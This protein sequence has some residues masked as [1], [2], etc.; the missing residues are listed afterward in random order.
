MDVY[1][2]V[3][4][5]HR[6]L[7]FPAVV[8][9]E[10][11]FVAELERT[12][13]AM[14]RHTERG[15]GL[16]AVTGESAEHVSAHIDRHGLVTTAAGTL[17]YAARLAAAAHRPLTPKLRA[18][19]C[20]RFATE[21]VYAYDAA[22]GAVLGE[23]TVEHTEHCGIGPDLALAVA[24]L[25]DVAAGVPVAFAAPAPWTGGR[26]MGQLDNVLAAA[27]GVELI[28]SGFPGSVL[29]T[30]GEEAGRSWEALAA[31]FEHP[32]ANL[33]VLDTSPFHKGP[34]DTGPFGNAGPV[35][36]GAVV[37]RHE[38]AGARFDDAATER[39]A[40]AATAAGAPIVWKDDVL[41]DAGRPLGRTELGRLVDATAGT[42]T[43]TTLQIPT[44]D[45]HSNHET[46]SRVAIQATM[47]VLAELYGL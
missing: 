19:V 11:P 2:V 26:F 47:R 17:A 14:G 20:H 24:G 28:E 16:L 7:E 45:Y 8:G 12:A 6:F 41:R 21:S 18:A 35:D 44:T 23:G 36:D 30:L 1:R 33:L 46:T 10:E 29:F 5:T 27:I 38:D 4:R 37:L 25:D 39:V 31:W 32:V 3:A 22:T 15:D 43:G 13:R 34:F 42:V 9:Y 40:A